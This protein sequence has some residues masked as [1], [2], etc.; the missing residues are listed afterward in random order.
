[1]SAPPE[2]I[3]RLDSR[4]FAAGGHR[5]LSL[6]DPEQVY[7]VEEGHLDIFAAEFRG[8]E[9]VN[10]RPF[11]TRVPAGSVAF[12]APRAVLEDRTFGFLGVPSRN[13]VIAEG[14]RS[15]L[16]EGS[17][18]VGLVAWIDD[19]AGRLS[20]FLARGRARC[21]ALPCCSRPTQAS[22]VPPAPR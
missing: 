20:E 6:D 18:D 22:P 3:E 9:V 8:A 13:A 19:W 11:A 12:G 15:R 14:K 10:R 17:L 2:L 21:R 5:P 1:M 4:R 7:L 16:T